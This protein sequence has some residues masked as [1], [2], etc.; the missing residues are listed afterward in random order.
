MTFQVNTFFGIF[1][2]IGT[3]KKHSFYV[4]IYFFKRA[5]LIFSFFYDFFFET[6]IQSIGRINKL[7]FFI[8][9]LFTYKMSLNAK[10]CS[11]NRKL[12]NAFKK[13]I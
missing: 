3:L 13:Y 2:K 7:L 10:N 6:Y 1:P 11:L 9:N 8:K 5:P 12:E 4:F